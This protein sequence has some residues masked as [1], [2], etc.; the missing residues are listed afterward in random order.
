MY[1]GKPQ[2]HCMYKLK[3]HGVCTKQEPV[4]QKK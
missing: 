3:K 2:G 4:D 1:T